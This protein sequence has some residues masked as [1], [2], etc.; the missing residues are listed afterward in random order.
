MNI[1]F[2]NTDKVNGLLTLTVEEGDYAPEVE[3]TLKDYRRRANVPGFRPGQ[4]PMGLI[5]KQFGAAAKM[6]AINKF[7]GEQIYKYIK[8]N[9]IHMLGEPLGSE[10]HEAVDLEK[11]APYTFKFDIAV[12][13]E[14]DAKLSKDDTVPYYTINVDDALI[15]KQ[16]EMFASRTGHYEKVEQYD[17]EKRD[18][19][20][21][22][23]RELDAEGNTKEGGITVSDAVLM[24]EYI[25]VDEQKA[26]FNGIKLGDI[27]TFNPRK[28][29]P[30][31]TAELTS[32]LKITKE[33]V[34]NL[35][36]DFSC[37]V[38][39][40]S[41]YASAPVDKALF[42]AIYTDGTV[43]TEEEFRARIADGLKKQL[44]TDSDYK[45]FVDVR[46]HLEQRIGQLQFPDALL[47]RIMLKGNADKGADYV[48]K[49]YEPSVKELA[50][51][52]MKDQLVGQTQIKVEKDDVR[53]AAKEAAAAQF[54]Q[55]G[56]SNIPEEYLEKYADDMMKK[57]EDADSFIR[58][59]IDRKLMTA[60]KEVVTLDEKTVS[61][62]EFNKMCE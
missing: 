59:A 49:N 10:D 2:E 44:A 50:W 11:P 54:A 17:A 56:M 27:I 41:R 6:D 29:Y 7:T 19:L 3:K 28:A 46:A 1:S 8:D 48:E 39:E 35:T 33:E 16:V 15:D 13:P 52:L 9:G 25:K 4:V 60:L 42:D 31:G 62:D 20:K 53:A 12:A 61:M 5:K 22:D 14:F 30:T 21:V 45:F 34:E 36:A 51:Q 58:R 18:M 37:Q 47:K 40:V 32:L 55:Y 26:L 24:P 23:L 57:E 38:T 43:N